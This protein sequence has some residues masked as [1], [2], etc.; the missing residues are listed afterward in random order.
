MEDFNLPPFFVNRQNSIPFYGCIAD[1]SAKRVVSPH[2]KAD[3]YDKNVSYLLKNQGSP[4]LSFT[5]SGTG[6][7]LP[8]KGEG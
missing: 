8:P 2:Q 4:S 5:L 1:S 6:G 7:L 3:F